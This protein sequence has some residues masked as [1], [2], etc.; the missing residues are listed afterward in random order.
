M[1]HLS[2]IHRIVNKYFADAPKSRSIGERWIS[3]LP[4]K[5]IETKVNIDDTLYLN[6]TLNNIFHLGF[7][8]VDRR[9]EFHHFF[10]DNSTHHAALILIKG[11]PEVWIKQKSNIGV[12]HTP[13]NIPILLRGEIK[14]RPND[15]DYQ[16]IFLNT[17]KMHYVG[18]FKKE[19]IDFSYWFNNLSFT[20]TVSLAEYSKNNKLYQIEFELDGYKEGT[21]PPD[22]NSI[23]SQ[24]EKMLM[25]IC[26]QYV[27]KL[28]TYTKLEWLREIKK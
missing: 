21:D 14:I 1:H 16:E 9:E 3:I 26:P 25:I 7:S 17:V 22:I 12:I 27:N 4:D 23:T 18:S 2:E 13:R 11:S 19:C 5:E 24:F 6:L 15:K 20:M 28:T 10:S 8:V